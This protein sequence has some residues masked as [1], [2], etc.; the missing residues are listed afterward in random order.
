MCGIVGLHLKDPSLESQL[1]QLLTPMLDCMTGRGPDSAGV[2]VYSDDLSQGEL[3]FSIRLDDPSS[4]EQVAERASE[5]LGSPVR[6]EQPHASGAVFVSAADPDETVAAFREADPSSLVIG[7]GKI[8]EV[9]KD[10]GLPG[11][12]ADRYDV[13][14]WTGYQGVG[15]TRMAT[16]SAVTPDHSHPFV[17]AP[18]LAVVHNGQFSNYA[19]IRRDLMREGVDFVTDNDTEV[20]ARYL[21]WRM[22]K[23]DDLR[24]ALE[25]VLRDFDGFFTLLVTTGDTF[26][27]VRDEFACK[28]AVIAETDAYVAMASEYHALAE[29]PGIGSATIWEPR[30]EEIHLW[31]R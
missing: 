8:V 24:T 18:D 5:L 23:G 1:G 30:P 20:C 3:R 31:T 15:H 2:A 19:T 25:G 27:V 10:V 22:S 14:K 9:V 29:L 16:E 13:P 7:F 6:V 28:P 11:E 12:V 4:A 17:P 21:A 26:A